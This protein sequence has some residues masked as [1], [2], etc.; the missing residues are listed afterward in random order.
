M[1]GNADPEERLIIDLLSHNK[2]TFPALSL[3][4]KKDLKDLAVN[5]EMVQEFKDYVSKLPNQP[6]DEYK[7]LFYNY[8]MNRK[9]SRLYVDEK[10]QDNEE[11]VQEFK[12]YVSKLPNQPGDEYKLLFYNYE[13]NRKPSRLYVDEKIQDLAKRCGITKRIQGKAFHRTEL[14]ATV[15][16]SGT[17]SDVSVELVESTPLAREQRAHT[18]HRSA[19]Y[20]SPYYFD[21]ADYEKLIKACSSDEEKLLIT[22]MREGAVSPTTRRGKCR[23]KNILA[24]SISKPTMELLV[25]RQMPN[26]KYPRSVH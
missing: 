15:G 16:Q 18:V 4:E 20:K 25:K 17:F 24:Q 9:P 1:W 26:Q 23:I 8:E 11:M 3:L 7:L 12:D 10:I 19:C 13:M 6:G 21:E 22:L 14:L 5:E 2:L